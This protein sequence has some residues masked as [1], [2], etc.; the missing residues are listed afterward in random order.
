MA[1]FWLADG[2]G[3]G[4]ATFALETNNFLQWQNYPAHRFFR[5]SVENNN[6]V[7]ETTGTYEGGASP[8]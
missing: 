2:R 3:V 4:W 7:V 8:W 6:E 1:Y 5:L